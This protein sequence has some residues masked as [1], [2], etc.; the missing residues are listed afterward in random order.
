MRAKTI[1][2]RRRRF[3]NRNSPLI[4]SGL[5]GTVLTGV[6]KDGKLLTWD[7]TPAARKANVVVCDS[8]STRWCIRGKSSAVD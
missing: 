2:E 3:F 5:I 6:V 1:V 8:Y 4:E 7:I